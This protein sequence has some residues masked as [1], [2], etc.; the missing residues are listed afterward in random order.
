MVVAVA[1]GLALHPVDLSP[2]GAV[3]QLVIFSGAAVFGYTV[4]ER[5]ESF[6]SEMVATRERAARA[7]AD[8]RARITRELHDIIGHAMSVMV[9]QAGVAEQLVGSDP[10]RARTAVREIGA[11]GRRSL[12]EMRQLI[13]ALRD[14]E[15]GPGDSL[16]RDPMPTLAQLPALVARVEAAGLP[17]T[18]RVHGEPQDL[19]AGL[20]LATYRVVQEALTNCLKHA[21]ATRATVDLVHEPDLVRVSVLDDGRGRA[22][23]PTAAPGQGLVGMRERVAVYG[24]QL[25]AGPAPAGGFRVDATFPVA[26]P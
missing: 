23:A 20:E 25:S 21:A 5:R 11:T 7:A 8:E 19:P 22:A 4:R 14:D 13:A 6:E 12:A 16:P 3:V 9:V 17:V 24:G 26:R 15:A 2:G 1:V 10:A 18:L